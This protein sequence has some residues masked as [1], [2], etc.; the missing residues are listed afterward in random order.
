MVIGDDILILESP[1]HTSKGLFDIGSRSGSRNYVV[2]ITRRNQREPLL[3][4]KG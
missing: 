3:M 2:E 1:S 4:R